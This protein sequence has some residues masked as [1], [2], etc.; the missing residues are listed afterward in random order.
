MAVIYEMK[1]PEPIDDTQKV[2]LVKTG[3][4]YEVIAYKGTSRPKV[5]RINKDEYVVKESGEVR[6]YHHNANNILNEKAFRKRLKEAMY[7]INA[8]CTT[9][10]NCLFLTVTYRLGK[11][12]DGNAIPMRDTKKLYSDLDKFIKKLKARLKEH[13]RI[14]CCEPQ[15]N[16]SWHAHIILIFNHR[17]PFIE[18]SELERLWGHGY[19]WIE[20]LYHIDNFGAYFTS[21]MSDIVNDE[22]RSKRKAK[23]ARLRFYPKNFKPIRFSRN[24]YQPVEMHVPYAKAKEIIGEANKTYSY[25][26]EVKDGE[27]INTV[28]HETYKKKMI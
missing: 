16:G 8:N 2:K 3:H 19:V 17:A 1:E 10:K 23:G 13:R 9:A 12:E 11:D 21:I 24:C 27:Y 22:D 25:A 4:F 7:R 5:T 28:T 18:H 20:N 14:I 26:V 6:E 15:S